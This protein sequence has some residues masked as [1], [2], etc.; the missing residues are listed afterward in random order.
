MRKELDKIGNK[1]EKIRSQLNAEAI[2]ANDKYLVYELLLVL[3]SAITDMPD[4]LAFKYEQVL[5][6]ILGC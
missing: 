1:L 3:Q 4:E 2:S 6:K 5:N